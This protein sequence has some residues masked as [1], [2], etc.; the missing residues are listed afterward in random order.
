MTTFFLISIPFILLLLAMSLQL[1]AALQRDSVAAERRARLMRFGSFAHLFLSL[2]GMVVLIFFNG[3]AGVIGLVL[4]VSLCLSI[5]HAV[6]RYAGV[7][8]RA[9]QAEF[10]WV[11]ATAV[12]S[13]RPLSTEIDAYAQGTS[14]RRHRLLNDMAERLHGGE[15]MTELVVPQG[16]LPA[17]ASMQ[18]HS[19]IAAMSLEES[20]SKTALRA[21]RD[22]AVDQQADFP[23]VGLAYPLILISIGIQIVGFIMYYIIPKF[24]R[25]FDDFNTELPEVTKSLIAGAD[26]TIRHWGVL[27]LPLFAY[28]PIG[29]IVLVGFAEYYSWPI[30]LQSIFGRWFIRWHTPDVMRSL[31]QSVTRGVPM[32][33]AL[34]P[35]VQ[36][37]GPLR[38]RR[39]LA[40]ALEDVQDGDPCWKTLQSRGIL[41]STETYVLETAERA[42]NLPWVLDTLADNLDRR[43]LYRIKALLE[44][45]Q[46]IALVFV[47]VAVGFVV[48]A[49]FMPLVKLFNDLA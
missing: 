40:L 46:P 13:G 37:A 27:G 38:L 4:S 2:I 29:I 12:K 20:L 24:K 45:V 28:L 7:Q 25:I 44:F 11:L 9:R 23:G 19:G 36:F 3:P 35:I 49:L 43:R 26:L 10:L 34:R 31:A 39:Q 21:T 42:G 30:L 15:S 14:G 18:I 16:L 22:L 47:G 6:I 33:Q 48:I 1:A 32:D 17:S 5:T 8:K 41:N